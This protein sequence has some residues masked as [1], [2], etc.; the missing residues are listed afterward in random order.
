MLIYADQ[1]RGN[2]DLTLAMV[3]HFNH[4]IAY[5][6][7]ADGKGTPMF[8]DGTAEYAS[9]FLPPMMDQGAKVLVVKPEGA[10]LMTV[11]K[12]APET[13]GIAQKWHVVVHDDGSAT[14][15]CDMSWR[16]DFAIQMRQMFSVEGQRT[17]VLQQVFRSFG[18]LTI[19]DSKFDDLKDFKKPESSFRV[20]IEIAKFVQGSGDALTLPTAFVDASGGLKRLVGRPTREHDLMMSTAM[21]FSIEADYELPPGWTVT[22]PPE[23]AKIEL[24]SASFVST[25][26]SDGSKLHLFR[27]MRMLGERVTVADYAAFRDAVIKA[28]AL[29]QQQWKVKKGEAPVAPKAPG[30]PA[31]APTPAETPKDG[32]GK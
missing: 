5:V 16:G 15:T 12:G 13:M 32:G 28:G 26:S 17:L 9:A 11:P 19:A 1:A 20:T 31:P 27:D 25:A 29:T 14:A 18:K 2:E 7:D 23:N 4:C 24:H 8:F 6:P 22:A 30:A 21:S 10:E 3:N